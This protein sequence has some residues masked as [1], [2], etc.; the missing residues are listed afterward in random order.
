MCRLW[1]EPLD[2]GREGERC[3]VAN[4]VVW[5]FTDESEEGEELLK[6]LALWKGLSS[7]PANFFTSSTLGA[8][9]FRFWLEKYQV[10]YV[11]K[12]TKSLRGKPFSEPIWVVG[13]PPEHQFNLDKKSEW[14]EHVVGYCQTHPMRKKLKPD[15]GRLPLDQSFERGVVQRVKSYDAKEGALRPYL[16]IAFHLKHDMAIKYRRPEYEVSHFLVWDIE[17][18]SNSA[19]PFQTPYAVGA[20]C[21]STDKLGELTK[22]LISASGQP[23]SEGELKQELQ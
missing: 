10:S 20:A 11:E 12:L 18:F 8:R 2:R 1:K 3:E 13:C 9:Q 7:Y 16:N 17:S 5:G 6:I 14:L 22:R 19:D 21:F 23:L 15:C 4:G